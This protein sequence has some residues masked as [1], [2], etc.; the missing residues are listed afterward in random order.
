M[1][2][3]ILILIAIMAAMLLIKNATFQEAINGSPKAVYDDLKGQVENFFGYEPAR[4]QAVL[5]QYDLELTAREQR[6]I[7][8][9]SETQSDLLIFMKKYCDGGQSNLNLSSEK[10]QIVCDS[11]AK[12]LSGKK[13]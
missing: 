3:L 6:Y 8:N 11:G 5:A 9:I 4:F 10:V 12:A 7:R 2:R 1:K 13:Y